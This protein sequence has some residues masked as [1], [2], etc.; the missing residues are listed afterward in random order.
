ML[1]FI[2]W[3]VGLGVDHQLGLWVAL[4][5]SLY[6][7]SAQL[8]WRLHDLEAGFLGENIRWL[9]GWEFRPLAWRLIRFLFYV[10]IPYGLVV[11]RQL[12]TGR[13][14]GV[15]GPEPAGFMG[16]SGAGWWDAVLWTFLI[17]L[18]MTGLL[19]GAWWALTRSLKGELVFYLHHRPPCWELFWD[20]FFL[21]VHWAFYR[22]A[23]QVWLGEEQPYWSIFLGLLLVGLETAGDPSLHFDRRWPSLASGWIRLAAVAWSS[24]VLF[25]LTQNLWLGV[26]AHWGMNWAINILGSE[27]SRWSLRNAPSVEA[28]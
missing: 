10:V 16:W 6:V 26:I 27:I 28:S 22:A 18:A 11:Q 20:A 8:A 1:R 21:Q 24:S 14:M 17:G 25:F 4:S 3:F 7:I 5:V 2:A 12:I 15:T 9:E 23:A 19:V 13:Q